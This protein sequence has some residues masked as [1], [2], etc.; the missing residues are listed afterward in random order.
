MD[1]SVFTTTCKSRPRTIGIA[2]RTVGIA[3]RTGVNSEFGTPTT[4]TNREIF[5]RNLTPSRNE[6]S[7]F[8]NLILVRKITQNGRNCKSPSPVNQRIEFDN[9]SVLS[10]L[11]GDDFPLVYLR[12]PKIHTKN[13][14]KRS[15]T[16]V[17]RKFK[18]IRRINWVLRL[19]SD[20]SNRPL[21]LENGRNKSRL[22]GKVVKGKC[23]YSRLCWSPVKFCNI[24]LACNQN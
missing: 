19:K 3:T 8:D 13:V 14:K 10:P 17:L 12:E 22:R 5:H 23:D 11:S 1:K 2:T 7:T 9:K 21:D 16:P 20:G 4:G 15:E 24:N 6:D 18:R